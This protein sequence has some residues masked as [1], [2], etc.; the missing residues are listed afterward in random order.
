MVLFILCTEAQ[1]NESSLSILIEDLN[2]SI[3][4]T[5]QLIHDIK[6]VKMNLRTA[7][8]CRY[9]SEHE[10]SI[11]F[12]HYET[13]TKRGVFLAN[14]LKDLIAKKN[15]VA[16]ERLR[17]QNRSKIFKMLTFCKKPIHLFT[18]NSNISQFKP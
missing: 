13:I 5:D 4:Q 18:C 2:T 15:A 9:N 6:T 1:C 14:A 3:N 7:I 8:E 16:I 12:N 17:C 11:V 10:K